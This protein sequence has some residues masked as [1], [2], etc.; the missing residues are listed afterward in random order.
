MLPGKTE[1]YLRHTQDYDLLFLGDSRTFCGLHPELID[2]LLGTR[3]FNL[4]HWANWLPTQFPLIQTIAAR[5]PK[6]TTVVY[7]IGMNNFARLTIHDTYPIG[8][9]NVPRYLALGIGTTELADNVLAFNPLTYLY[10]KRAAV[11]EHVQALLSSPLRRTVAQAP[12]VAAPADPGTAFRARP[13]VLRVEVQAP[14][15]EPVAVSQFMAGG[16]YLLEELDPAH[17]RSRQVRTGLPATAYA[18]DQTRWALFVAVLDLLRGQ[19]LRVVVNVFEEAPY[20][21]ADAADRERE[22]SLLDGRVRNEVLA[23]G[24]LYLRTNLD[25]LTDADYFDYNHLNTRGAAKLAAQL[26]QALAPH[27]PPVGEK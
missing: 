6:G 4:S 17:F 27:L 15:G 24:F 20:R 11:R 14:E 9:S 3:S 25:E 19:G 12:P 8:L 26:A 1:F 16:G 13:G 23:H 21:Y 18:V 7:S 10:A 22:R 5:I 2:P